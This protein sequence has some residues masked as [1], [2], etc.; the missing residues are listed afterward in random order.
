MFVDGTKDSPPRWTAFSSSSE[1]AQVVFDLLFVSLEIKS[2]PK[3]PNLLR[4]DILPWKI[5]GLGNWKK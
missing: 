5:R 4:M 1:V 2:A 3:A